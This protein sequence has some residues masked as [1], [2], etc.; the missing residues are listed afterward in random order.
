[1]RA[2]GASSWLILVKY[3]FVHGSTTGVHIRFLSVSSGFK[4]IRLIG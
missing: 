1:V 4:L 2:Y 3:N